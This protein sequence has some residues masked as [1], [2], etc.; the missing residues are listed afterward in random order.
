[1]GLIAVAVTALTN[2]VGTKLGRHAEQQTLKREIKRYNE[3][4]RDALDV[5][6]E[7]IYAAFQKQGNEVLQKYFASLYLEAVVELAPHVLVL[8]I[9]QRVYATAPVL[10]FPFAFQ[11]GLGAI[12]WYLCCALAFH[13]LVIKPI[14]RRTRLGVY[15][16]DLRS[17]P[18]SGKWRSA[19]P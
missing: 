7:A 10:E 14:K 6:H 4:S 18:E 2:T 15:C 11:G 19:A 17:E 5:G 8:G 12:P 16:A 9:L 1:M 3:L 13:F